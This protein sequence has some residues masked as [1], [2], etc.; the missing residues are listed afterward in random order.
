MSDTGESTGFSDTES[1]DENEEAKVSDTIS[2]H[3]TVMETGQQPEKSRCIW[4]FYVR[5]L[6]LLILL[7]GTMQFSSLQYLILH[8][9]YP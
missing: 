4:C 6:H 5:T 9:N 7:Q 3:D 1:K 8:V 2:S